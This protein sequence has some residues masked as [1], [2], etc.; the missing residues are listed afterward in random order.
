MTD[1]NTGYWNTGDRNTGHGNTGHRNTGHRNTGDWNTGDWNMG[2][3][4]TTTPD[5]VRV[6]DGPEVNRGEFIAACPLWLYAPS[7]T[8]WIADA[9]MSDT[10][11]LENPTFHTCGGYLRVND[12]HSEWRKAYEGASP[13]DIQRVRDLPGFDAKVFEAITGLDLTGADCPC[14]PSE[15]MIDGVRYVRAD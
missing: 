1:T 5:K 11:K 12:W 8:T 2:Y 10:E 13:E 7:P 9:N 15:V 6:F 3:F 14:E 4:N